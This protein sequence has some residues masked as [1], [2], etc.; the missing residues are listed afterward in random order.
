MSA[1]LE[2]MRLAVVSHVPHYCWQ[3]NLYAYAAYAREIEIWADLFHQVV[4][5]APLRIGPP[6]GDCVRFEHRNISVRPQLESGGDSLR[7][8]AGLVLTMPRML[9]QLGMVLKDAD[10]IHVR[11]PGNLGILGA[12]LGPLF[13][14]NL[15]AKYAGQWTDF[16][17]EA[18]TTRWQKRLLRS[19]WFR[20]PVTV[21]GRWPGE[22]E[23]IV[24]FFT[25][26]LT[27]EQIARARVAAQL[28]RPPG[29]LRI[30]FVGRLSVAKNIDVLL[31]AVAEAT[32]QNID[33]RCAI[34]GEGPE[35]PALE[36]LSAELQIRD[37]VDFLGGLELDAVLGQF[38]RS[39]MLVLASETEG[40]PKAI[41][42]AMAFGLICVGSNRG[43]VPQIL[44]DGRGVVIPPRDVRALAA[45]I[46]HAAVARDEY[47]VMRARAAAWAHQYSL[48]GLREALGALLVERWRVP[49]R[50]VA[51]A[52][53]GS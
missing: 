9:F 5:A 22:P 48:E 19:R 38:E 1:A 40:W 52:A 11:C 34:V 8:K 36:R 7:A 18:R 25:S 50:Q 44:A 12:A 47:G 35:R 46:Q 42:E 33:V 28:N 13:S 29:P 51:T 15:V 49:A 24:P 20:G 17:G 21:Y 3:G 27:S 32:R 26:V 6:P 2:S 23:H 37:S 30:V 16:P 39:D 14:R 45:A 43:L 41:T 31:R 4:I 10:A 53:I